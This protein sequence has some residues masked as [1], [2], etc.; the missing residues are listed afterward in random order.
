MLK[1]QDTVLANLMRLWHQ[2]QLVKFHWHLAVLAGVDIDGSNYCPLLRQ[3]MVAVIRIGET[4]TE[5]CGRDQTSEV[6]RV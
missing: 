3:L 2:G 4:H 6:R 5:R 1:P